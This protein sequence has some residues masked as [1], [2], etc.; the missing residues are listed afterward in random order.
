MKY[1][2][3]GLEI[4]TNAAEITAV[5]FDTRSGKGGTKHLFGLRERVCFEMK[6]KVDTSEYSW[7]SFDATQGEQSNDPVLDSVPQ[8]LLIQGS[9]PWV[10]FYS[11]DSGA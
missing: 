11:A 8:F 10:D 3:A 7:A 5:L 9:Q 4:I 6:Y 1:T 2:G